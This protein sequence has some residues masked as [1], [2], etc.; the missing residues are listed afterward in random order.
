MRLKKTDRLDAFRLFGKTWTVQW[1]PIEGCAGKTYH[2]KLL[3]QVDPNYAPEYVQ[4]TLLH[5]LTHA[6]DSEME[7]DMTEHQVRNIA[8]GLLGI[9]KDN[10][11]LCTYIFGEI[12]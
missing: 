8:T 2:S 9:M 4:D 7:L 5:E 1:L 6:V 10:P 3:I 11:A 12:G